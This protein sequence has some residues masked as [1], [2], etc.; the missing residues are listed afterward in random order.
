VFLLVGDV[1]CWQIMIQQNHDCLALNDSLKMTNQQISHYYA[2]QIHIKTQP[3]DHSPEYNQKPNFC[4]AYVKG[5]PD[6][7]KRPKTFGEGCTE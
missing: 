6:N 4:Q 2:R 7:N 1:M 3:I 5:W